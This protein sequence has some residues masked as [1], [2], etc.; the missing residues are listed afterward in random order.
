LAEI[1]EQEGFS[2]VGLAKNGVEALELF[3]ET[4]PDLGL[5]DLRMPDLDGAD[6]IRAIRARIAEAKLIVLSTFG[7][8]D[9]LKRALSAGAIQY[10]VKDVSRA[11]LVRTLRSALAKVPAVRTG[12][13]L[14]TEREKEVLRLL[15]AGRANKV[16]AKALHITEGTVKLHVYRIYKKL[17]VRSRTEALRL[18]LHSGLGQ[19]SN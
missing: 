16:I 12:V 17:G 15:V 4:R 7:D 9:G 10:L 5:I 2:V 18:A 19:L 11:E 6:C 8:E 1:L 13:P 14:L 3:L